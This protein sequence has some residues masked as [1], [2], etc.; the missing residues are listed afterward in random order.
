[1]ATIVQRRTG[2]VNGNADRYQGATPLACTAV[3]LIRWYIRQT[4]MICLSR[5]HLV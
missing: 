5:G 1:M 3:S 4:Q 2:F